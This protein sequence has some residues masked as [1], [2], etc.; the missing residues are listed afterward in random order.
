MLIFK[1]NLSFVA[2]VWTCKARSS[3]KL[4]R[5]GNGPHADHLIAMYHLHVPPPTLLGPPRT[6]SLL[7]STSPGFYSFQVE[8][9]RRQPGLYHPHPLLRM[10]AREVTPSSL[11]ASSFLTEISSCSCDPYHFWGPGAQQK[12]KLKQIGPQTFSLK[13]IYTNIYDKYSYTPLY[14]A[15]PTYWTS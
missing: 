2:T 3:Q 13:I 12:L 15:S 14:D 1:A 11:R 5:R 7:F 8:L 4:Y 9:T 10:T 6:G